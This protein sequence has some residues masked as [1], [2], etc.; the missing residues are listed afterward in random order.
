MLFPTLCDLLSVVPVPVLVPVLVL[1]AK[2]SHDLGTT[3]LLR[4]AQTLPFR[5][6]QHPLSLRF[7]SLKGVARSRAVLMRH[8]A[9]PLPQTLLTFCPRLIHLS[10]LQRSFDHFILHPL[11]R[12]GLRSR[13][14]IST[15]LARFSPKENP[16]PYLNGLTRKLA[17]DQVRPYYLYNP[18]K[19]PIFP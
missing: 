10:R 1:P 11:P 2:D 19:R 9:V 7:F 14:F 16:S 15:S 12:S 6:N 17:F 8:M 4:L 5:P 18:V 13:P 3:N